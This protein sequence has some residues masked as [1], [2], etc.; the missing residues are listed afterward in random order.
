MQPPGQSDPLSGCFL[1]I[2]KAPII[3]PAAI[4]HCLNMCV[5]VRWRRPSACCSELWQLNYSPLTQT[6][7]Q[8]LPAVSSNWMISLETVG[9]VLWDLIVPT[10]VFY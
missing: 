3:S 6:V 9:L 1:E 10:L 5:C 4:H 7:A 2:N 8:L